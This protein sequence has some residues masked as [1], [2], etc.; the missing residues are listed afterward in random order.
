MSV[1]GTAMGAGDADAL[2]RLLESRFPVAEGRLM[3]S[4]TL[5]AVEN[6][7][8]TF[9]LRRSPLQWRRP[10][11]EVRAVADVNLEICEGEV[12]GI[13]GE[14]GSG[15]T[16]LG[17]VLADIEAPSSGTIKIRGRSLQDMS[18]RDRKRFRQKVQ[19]VFQDSSSALNPRRKVGAILRDSLRLQG[20][21]RE[22]RERAMEE[23]LGSVGLS[24]QHAG[25]YPHQLSG[26]QR[27]RIGIARALA[28]QPEVLIADEP[29]SALDVSVQGQIINLLL[30][31]RRKLNLTIIL[32]SHDIAIVHHVSDRIAVMCAGEIVETGSA[33]DVI[34]APRHPYTR[35]L[36]AAIPRGIEARTG[37]AER[38]RGPRGPLR[39]RHQGVYCPW[40]ASKNETPKSGLGDQRSE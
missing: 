33:S 32:I 21:A 23:L 36:I 7:C 12:F 3:Q 19:V 34:K 40:G 9:A 39:G 35:S 5:F 24:M 10:A 25:R 27:Q 8:K 11:D 38:A 1:A 18:R 29:A 16:T 2:L 22:H 17:F 31:L 13:I 14:S 15:K 26:G 20:L 6:V 37:E 4:G 28:M 30:E